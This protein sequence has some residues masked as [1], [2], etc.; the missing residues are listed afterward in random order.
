VVVGG[1]HAGCEAA[2]ASARLGAS[3]L[4]VS[5]NLDTIAMASC[6]PAIGGLGKGQLVYEIDAFGGII[7]QAADANAIHC[8]MLNESKGIA[9]QGLRV[10]I[11]KWRYSKWM[12]HHLE[13]MPNLDLLMGMV[14]Q[15]LYESD[16]KHY[17]VTGI[18]LENDV[19]VNCKAVILTTGTFLDG[20]IYNG[21]KFFPGGRAGER[22]ADLLSK[23][24]DELGILKGRL[25]T[26]TPPRLHRNSI[27]WDCL[28]KQ[29]GDKVPTFFHYKTTH[30]VLPQVPCYLTETN[31]KTHDIIR[32]NLKS[33][34]MYGGVISSVGPRYCPSIEDKVVR[35]ASRDS[36]HI[37]LEPEGL[38]SQEIYANG[39]SSSLPPDVQIDLLHTMHGLSHVHVIRFAYAIEYTYVPPSQIKSTLEA[40][41][42]NGLFMAGQ[43][44][45]TTGYEEAAGLGVIAG[46]NAALLAQGNPN[47]LVFKRDEAYLGVMIDDLRTREHKEPYRMLT[48]RA[49]FRLFLRQD[50][51]N[52][53]LL[54]K[55][56]SIGLVDDERYEHFLTY[57]TIVD[58]EIKR[59]KSTSIHVRSIS[60][61]LQAK[62][63]LD[64]LT[65]GLKISSF[66][67][68]QGNTYEDLVLLGLASQQ[69][70]DN[71]TESKKAI[72]EIELSL[73]YEPYIERARKL[74]QH[75][76]E[77]DNK[78]IPDCI[79][80]ASIH[81][82]RHEA[83]Q[84][85]TAMH[86]ETIG[87]AS[88]IPGVNPTDI[89]Q[90]LIHLKSLSNNG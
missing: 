8:R 7:P 25:K 38:D 64:T 15:I 36:H 34:A 84:K 66:L 17:Y 44:N 16:G 6:N 60:P 41:N 55:A 11:D 12:Q 83:L 86:P 65:H 69:P 76:K 68:R 46:T 40:I 74:S 59:F 32:K 88:R 50:N 2:G 58:N 33:S 87:Q 39:L 79:D 56:H 90:I 3:T 73:K 20:I 31:S 61:D 18:K 67:A 37:F 4:L 49:E 82:L 28:E 30:H 71:P 81:G 72:E 54:D 26:G 70:M 48:S 89:Q 10:Q 9:V 43:I 78:H 27:D 19:T 63:N 57:K 85:L 23:S 47:S 75:V 13:H 62:Y 35:F 52:L 21:H 24:F 80:Y 14:T 45:G 29:N 22:S 1:G 53:R 77:L 42:V 5:M 51:A